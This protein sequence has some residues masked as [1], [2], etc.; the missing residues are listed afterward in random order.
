[1]GPAP[2]RLGVGVRLFDC[3]ERSDLLTDA[4]A[5]L[6]TEPRYVLHDAG[7]QRERLE[8]VHSRELGLRVELDQLLDLKCDD[9][10]DG[11]ALS[12]K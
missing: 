1:L 11:R 3:S 9:R 10:L 6:R 2:L 4:G 12:V 7:A 5:G 8:R